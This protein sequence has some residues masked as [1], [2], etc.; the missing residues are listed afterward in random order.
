MGKRAL[1]LWVN[2]PGNPAGA[3][4]DLGA[5]ADWGRAGAYRWCPT[6]ATRVHVGRT[7][8]VGAPAWDQRA[9]WLSIRFPSA[10]TWPGFRV[11]FYAGDPD[12][13][14]YLRETRRHQGFLIPGPAQ[15]AGAAALRDQ[16]HV[17]LQADRYRHRL[18]S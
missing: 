18:Q 3:L 10:P 1:C 11:G 6:S 4:D 16:V 15:V 7:I 13:T 9:C 2:T 17:D 8:Q 12:L 5:A 14:W